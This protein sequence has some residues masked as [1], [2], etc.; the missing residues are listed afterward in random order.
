MHNYK[1]IEEVSCFIEEYNEAWG[2]LSL[3]LSTDSLA[4]VGNLF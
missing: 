2:I 1:M 3:H 4:V